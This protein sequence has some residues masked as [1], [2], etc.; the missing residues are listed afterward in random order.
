MIKRSRKYLSLCLLSSLFV[1]CFSSLARAESPLIE[2]KVKLRGKHIL[3]INA[4]IGENIDVKIISARIGNYKHLLN[5]TLSEPGGKV[6]KEKQIKP[7]G[8]AAILE[9]VK[10]TGAYQLSVN[11]GANAFYVKVA[12]RYA[13]IRTPLKIIGSKPNIFFYVPEGITKF[14]VFLSGG[15][16]N[17]Q[18]GIDIFSSDDSKVASGDTAGKQTKLYFNVIV[19]NGEDGKIWRAQ[20]RKVSGKYYEEMSVS[21][22][23]EIP[24]YVFTN[25]KRLLKKKAEK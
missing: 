20:I 9:P 8:S 16:G 1:L 23:E 7:G 14:T 5:Y 22:S 21:F 13:R 19:P 18:A 4:E 6:I 11:H 17:E 15:G 2:D 24:P 25:P 10:K 3:Y 12:N